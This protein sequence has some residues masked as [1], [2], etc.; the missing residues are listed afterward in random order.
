MLGL[1]NAITLGFSPEYGPELFTA[2]NAAAD[3][4]GA[5]ADGIAGFAQ[6]GLNGTGA[7]VYQSQ[8]S[9]VSVGTY[10]LEANANDTPSSGARISIDLEAAPYNFVNG[11]EGKIE[12]DIR[13]VGIGG[14]WRCGLGA[15]TNPSTINEDVLVTDL[16]YDTKIFTWVHS[17]NHRFLI[18]RENSGTDD[19][20]IY[21]DNLS[22][23][24][25]I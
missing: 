18:T 13:H 16:V 2:A 14:D 19:G 4:G 5:E 20:G 7:N 17:A 23:K 15:A 22:I 1:G 6:V 12:L 3:P 8:S 9:V 24:K 11:E 25:K 10:A 21:E